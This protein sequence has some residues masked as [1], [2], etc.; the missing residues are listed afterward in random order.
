MIELN[1]S[2][3][4]IKS[5]VTCELKNNHL[6]VHNLKDAIKREELGKHRISVTTFLEGH[7]YK[8]SATEPTRSSKP[9]RKKAAPKKKAAKK[10]TAKAKPM[11][12]AITLPKAG[13]LALVVEHELHK[14]PTD[15]AHNYFHQLAD[16][17]EKTR[18]HMAAVSV[19]SLILCAAELEYLKG[20]THPQS[21]Q[22]RQKGKP[23]SR[24]GLPWKQWVKENCDFSY[25]TATKYAKVLKCARAGLIENLDPSMVPEKAPSLMSSDELQ[26]TCMTLA[27]AL[28]GL[29]GRRQLYLQ[30]DVIATPQRSTIEENR[31][32][33]GGHKKKPAIPAADS[34]SSIDLDRADA[35]ETFRAAILKIDQAL[36]INQ[37]LD[38]HPD[39]TQELIDDLTDHIKQLKNTLKKK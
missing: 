8:L 19:A 21:M 30:L 27:Q 37:H 11:P 14:L 33:K 31:N 16:R 12:K 3:Q 38:L 1:T 20:C 25:M 17:A 26:D 9:G 32:T 34:N 24:N 4:D 36:K 5:S 22:P 2:V 15:S 39:T 28:Q 18:E 29:G 35:T 13:D 10:K 6:T 23:L 7:L